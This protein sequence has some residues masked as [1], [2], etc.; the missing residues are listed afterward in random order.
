MQAILQLG[1]NRAF[2]QTSCRARRDGPNIRAA[3]KFSCNSLEG[4]CSMKIALPN[5]RTSHSI[6]NAEATGSCQTALECKDREDYKGAQKAMRRLW[7][8]VGER[9]DTR[10]LH[11]SV[12]AE[13][14][15]CV[16]ILTGWLGSKNQIK[17]AQETA[18]DLISESITYF[19]S[20][21]D[22]RRLPP[23]GLSWR[24]VITE[25]AS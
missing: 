10:G 2:P 25:R 5:L 21:R 9:P 18:K 4:I 7:P 15:L 20:V 6:T 22:F 3:S 12:E 11:V 14:L 8:S 13:V 24:S 17:T 23:R 19:A 1:Q 16:G